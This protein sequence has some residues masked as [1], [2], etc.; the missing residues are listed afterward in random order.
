MAE[1]VHLPG[2]HFPGAVLLRAEGV[3]VPGPP[4]AEYA[5]TACHDPGAGRLVRPVPSTARL[6]NPETVRRWMAPW[7]R[8]NPLRK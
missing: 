2:D 6:P 8:P 4:P 1:T 7:A 5:H 3:A